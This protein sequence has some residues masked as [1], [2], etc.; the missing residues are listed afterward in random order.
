MIVAKFGGTSVQN[1]QA[2]NQV[3]NIVRSYNSKVFVVVS[4]FAGITNALVKLIDFIN[5]KSIPQINN[6]TENIFLRH[7]NTARELGVEKDYIKFLSEQKNQFETIVSALIAIGET[8]SRSAD[9]IL[10]FG[11]LLSS[12]LVYLYF[13]KKGLDVKYF[14]PRELIKT[15]S[16]FTAAEIDFN[17]TQ[18]NFDQIFA[19]ESHQ[20]F[21]TGGF[22]G[23]DKF[24][25]TTTLSRGGSDYSA[26]AIASVVNAD[27]LHIWTDVSGIMTAD[28]K[29]I[30]NAQVIPELS[31]IE[32]AELAYFGA[33]VLHPKTI[34]PAIKKNIPVKVL[35]T[36]EPNEKGTLILP[37]AKSKKI[38]KA[39][40]T[41]SNNVIVTIK[42]NHMLGAYGFLAKVFEVFK[43]FKTPVD[44][45]S[46]S[47]VSISLT[48]DNYEHL[49]E[50]C[51]EL[52]SFSTIKIERNQTIISVI[53]EGLKDSTSV[54]YRIFNALGNIKV[55]MI[56]MGSSDVNFSFVV[57]SK[58]AIEATKS[59]HKEFFE[60]TN[61]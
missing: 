44:L 9:L 26:S 24:G 32:A 45:V 29:I 7:R 51:N 43:K 60:K 16:N 38:V 40:T 57:N 58:D 3:Y 35:N 30:Q 14:D 19:N 27:E 21:V 10:S 5:E 13:L 20:F 1:S 8:T 25:N 46:T 49:K 22:V 31:Y 11:E 15:D 36:F 41:R 28:P 23:S 12:K 6:L 52:K 53:G 39:I 4:A 56:S 55:K 42:S 33:K 47:E 2:I 17:L 59:I 54:L 34:Y 18:K 48:I 37:K 50:I 61:E